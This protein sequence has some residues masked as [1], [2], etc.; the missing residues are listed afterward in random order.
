MA[1][2][3]IITKG[4]KAYP[5]KLTGKVFITCLVAAMGGLIF[6]YDI[7]ISAGGVTSMPS[8]LKKFFPHVY[9]KE[10]NMVPGTN[11]YCKFDD[12]TLTLFT[13][14][15]YLAAL[16]A[17]LFASHVTRLLGRKCSMLL[18]GS[19]FLTGAVLNGFAQNVAM[20]IF[21]RIFLGFGIGFANQSAPVY[22]SEMA[23]YRYRGALNMCFQ[24]F[25][26]L[27]ILAANLINYWTAKSES[28]WRVSLG[29]AA[30]PAL[31]F[32]VG[33]LFL[34][35]TPNSLIERGHSD[36]ALAMLRKV[37]GMDDV[38]DEFNDLVAAASVAASS[39]GQSRRPWT[40]LLSRKHRPHLTMVTAIPFFQ[41]LTGMNVF[42]F[43]A[44]VLFRTIGFGSNASLM[45]A[46]ITGIVNSAA[47]LVSILTVDRFGRR[48]LFVEGGLQ[49]LVCQVVITAC[50]GGKFGVD[51]DPG[52]LPKWYAGLVVV[53]ICLYVAAFAWSWGPLGWLVPSEVLPLEVRSAGQ[54]VNVAV[55]MIFT[56]FV[57]EMFLKMLCVMKF[58]LFVFFSVFV[59]AMTV[60]VWKFVPET[61]GIPIEDMSGIWREHWYWKR[62]VEEGDGDG[63]KVED[64]V[65][66]NKFGDA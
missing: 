2:G 52:E 11:S 53:A 56:F 4:G 8:F 12:A 33:S 58:G 18:G 41:Q 42:M 43:Y 44:P 20:L 25:I 38:L 50:I 3:V 31:L 57:A 7:G 17:S 19:L 22:L 14:S 65:Q 29:C 45:S 62:F 6:G 5:G 26:T 16:V 49:M 21:G 30:A 24:L 37:R 35:D 51:G 40:E 1:G 59:M 32:I 23:P 39:T 55:N 36:R 64:G 15:L 27:G 60:F 47:T 9:E 54:S 61:K 63:N 13:S 10:E 28:G 66:M 34:P 48:V 46:V